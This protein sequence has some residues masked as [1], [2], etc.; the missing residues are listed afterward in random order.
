M[1]PANKGVSIFESLRDVNITSPADGDLIQF[2]NPTSKWVNRDIATILDGT[3][4]R[5]DGD[6]TPILSGVTIKFANNARLEMLDGAFLLWGDDTDVFEFFNDVTKTFT[7]IVIAGTTSHYN[8]TGVS[9]DFRICGDVNASLFWLEGI[10]AVD[11][12][13]I[14]IQPSL[15]TH[16]DDEIHV[17]E[18]NAL[19]GRTGNFSY[20]LRFGSGAAFT[21]LILDVYADSSSGRHLR[22][23]TN[24]G[25]LQDFDFTNLGGGKSRIVSDRALINDDIEIDGDL[26]HDGT[27]VG[28]F[29]V[30]PAAQQTITGS[31]AGNA[32]LADLLTKGAL[33]GYWIDNTTA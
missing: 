21:S 13:G 19:M 23:E 27:N 33:N 28:L 30:A 20:K 14:G 12:V 15:A 5:R 10:S 17:I 3:Y 31:R 32:A 18:G 2:D 7:N 16:Y 24:H 4:I 26:N 25:L 11:A 9:A 1:I 29:S 6:N 8:L 22:F